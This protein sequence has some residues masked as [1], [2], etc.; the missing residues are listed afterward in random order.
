MSLIFAR[1]AKI[2]RR[3]AG[4]LRQLHGRLS[5]GGPYQD[6]RQ[7]QTGPH[8][9]GRDELRHTKGGRIQCFISSP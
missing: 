4:L 6:V 7:E 8:H 2:F 3:A 5:D 1:V 9:L